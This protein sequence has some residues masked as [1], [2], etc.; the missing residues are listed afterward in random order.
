MCGFFGFHEKRIFWCELKDEKGISK[1]LN[2]LL[3]SKWVV[4]GLRNEHS[5]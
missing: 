2:R 1:G 3:V 5:N 4:I